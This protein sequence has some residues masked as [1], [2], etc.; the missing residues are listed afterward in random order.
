MQKNPIICAIDTTDLQKAEELAISLK[1]QVGALKI[2][3]EFFSAHGA[4]GTDFVASHGIPIF[5][6]LKFH[7]IPNTVAGAVRATA[8]IRCFM[9]TV[10]AAGGKAMMKAASEASMEVASITGK[11]RP[12]VVG[13]T[14][15]TSMDG[16]DAASI[17][18]SGALEEQVKRLAD[19]AQ[20]SGLDGV[21]CSPHEIALLRKQC[22]DDFTLVVP[23]IRPEGSEN[24]DQKR[25][26]TPKEA[27]AQ[28]ANYLVIGRPI[29][30]A[31]HASKAAQ[32]IVSSL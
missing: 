19:L 29:T 24:G 4:A 13:V 21:V 15:L 7:D 30:G 17:G 32:T 2:G 16:A 27:L 10:H 22:G 6:D 8:G 26:M 28:G 9:M 5:L 3:L 11:E 20:Q 14:M 18:V 23:G 1:G 12:M 25:V 31:A